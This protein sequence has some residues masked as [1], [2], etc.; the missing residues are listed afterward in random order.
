M[1]QL[2]IIIII[3]FLLSSCEKEINIDLNSS[4]PQFV[5]EGTITN[6]PGPYFVKITKTVNFSDGN[7]FPRVSNASVI[8]SDN[9]GNSE[10][11]TETSPG[12]YKTNTTTGVPGRTYNLSV[13]AEGKTFYASSTMPLPVILDSLKFLPFSGPTGGDNYST[14]PVFTDPAS[15]SNNYHFL[16]T[17]NGIPDKSYILFNDNATNG[18]VN[19]R[20]AFNPQTEI[21]TGDSVKIEM[22]CVDLNTYTYFFTLSQIAGNGPGG[23]TT[24]TNPPNNFT[25]DKTL[26]Y[27]SAHVTQSKTQIVK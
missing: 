19:Q 18:T 8:I 15:E 5:I 13:T 27:F 12:V 17:V 21:K 25:G 14:I 4:D 6:Q 1:K 9:L 20:P 22:R 16:L 10:T 2:I 26:G 24:P 7:N 11:L 23:G 3:S